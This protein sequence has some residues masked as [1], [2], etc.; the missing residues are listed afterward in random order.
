MGKRTNNII[1]IAGLLGMLT[2][3][4]GCRKQPV[5]ATQVTA[6]SYNVAGLPEGISSSHPALYSTSISVLL[7]GFNVVHLQEDFCYHDSIMLYNTH[8]Y[9]TTTTGCVPQGDG[10]NTLSDYPVL[11][12]DRHAWNH[13]TGADCLTPKGFYFSQLHLNDELV[14]DFYNVH[15]NAGSS[16]A[17]L[18]AR[19]NNIAQ[20][21]SYIQQHSANN[22]VVIMGDFNS[23]YT[24]QGDT[25][26]ALLDLGFKDAWIELVRGG[27]VPG[28]SADKLENCEPDRTNPNCER[29]DKF[30]Y[31]SSNEVA[32][33]ADK[34]K[35]DDGRFYY[36]G[37]DTLQL[38]D[39]WPLFVTFRFNRK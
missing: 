20:L 22:P 29:V 30:F 11:N 33:T 9:V 18:E 21:C 15:C 31:R 32:I 5:N 16:D 7:N 1:L 8:P 19:R 4:T 23:R 3:Y 24:R 36:N 27:L 25:I 2:T 12:V 28:I 13:C 35:V 37:N 38:S 6:V 26:A 34:Y 17:S 14:I 39:H 10:L